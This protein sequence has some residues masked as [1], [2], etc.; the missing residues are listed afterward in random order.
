MDSLNISQT[1]VVLGLQLI[2]ASKQVFIFYL[3]QH[4]C[5]FA[6]IF[7]MYFGVENDEKP[8]RIHFETNNIKDSPLQD[9]WQFLSAQVTQKMG[10]KSKWYSEVPSEHC[11]R[12]AKFKGYRLVQV[13]LC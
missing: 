9:F 4:L 8:P 10:Q 2:F 3:L 1:F 11:I 5:Y 12:N 13:A 6:V 7:T